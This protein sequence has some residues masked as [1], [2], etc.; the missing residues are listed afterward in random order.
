MSKTKQELRDALNEA[1]HENRVAWEEATAAA[2]RREN[3]IEAMQS[4]LDAM[5]DGDD[6][7]TQSA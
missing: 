4:E 5:E 7:S 1:K 6:E 2:K 3:E